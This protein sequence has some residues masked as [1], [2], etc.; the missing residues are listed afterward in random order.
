MM[1][2][3]AERVWPALAVRAATEGLGHR[4]VLQD[5]GVIDQVTAFAT[6]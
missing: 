1:F 4:K 2:A 6:S 3:A 5:P